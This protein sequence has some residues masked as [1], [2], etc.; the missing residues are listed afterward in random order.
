MHRSYPR[1]FSSRKRVLL[2]WSRSVRAP[3]NRTKRNE[4]SQRAASCRIHLSLA[5]M[6]NCERQRT[7]AQEDR[8]ERGQIIKWGSIEPG[9]RKLS[10]VDNGH[11]TRGVLFEVS[12][13]CANNESVCKVF[14]R[15]ILP[16]QSRYETHERKN[17]TYSSPRM[18]FIPVN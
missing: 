11:R 10:A 3:W 2:R 7:L 14:P 5:L 15:P 12:L 6:G 9:E 13:M 1:L 16:A 18:Q 4:G 17:K 8:T